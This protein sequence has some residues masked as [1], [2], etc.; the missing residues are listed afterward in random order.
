MKSLLITIVAVVSTLN[1][2]CKKAGTENV[3]LEEAMKK[4]E[5]KGF[6]GGALVAEKGKVLFKDGYGLQNKE[7]EIK[8]TAETIFPYG[9][10]VKD[11]TRAAALL[12]EIDGKISLSDNITKYFSNIPAD[13][14]TITVE[15]LVSHRSGLPAYFDMHPEIEARWPD[16]PGD[17]KPVTKKEAENYIL[18]LPLGFEPGTKEEYSNAG[19]T[20][21]A[22]VI[23]KATGMSFENVVAEKF[24]KPANMT[25][26][27]FIG[28]RLWPEDKVATGYG[29]K[30]YKKNSPYHWPKGS[31]VL[32][33]GGGMAGTMEDMYKGKRYLVELYKNNEA[34]RALYDK[35]TTLYKPEGGFLGTAGGND[36]GFVTVIMFNPETDQYLIIAQNNN[37]G[38]GEDP[39]L[40]RDALLAAFDFDLARK[41]PDAY[42]EAVEEHAGQTGEPGKWGLPESPKFTRFNAFCD[43]ISAGTEA[44]VWPFIQENFTQEF[45]DFTSKQN[46]EEVFSKWL[47]MEDLELL[48]LKRNNN[49]VELEI[50]ANN[51]EYLF[52]FGIAPNTK[53]LFEG[54][55]LK[56]VKDL[57]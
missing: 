32:L 10:I 1:L 15:H 4:H 42:D 35:Y 38:G 6:Y 27:D 34:Y 31:N 12:L 55:Q 46:H 49:E 51:K 7:Q 57:E 17:F 11:Y 52:V 54:I 20:L 24:F 19:Y 33:G 9:S 45:Q 5:A 29:M 47:N 40:M 28:S 22:L 16:I 26:T 39:R 56:S 18:D 44:D 14:Q 2:T 8:N 23:E 3:T 25:H 36:F 43:L 30:T 53:R 48:G 50:S 13:K 41:Y 37:D 21:L